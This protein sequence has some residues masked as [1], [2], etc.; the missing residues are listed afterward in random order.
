MKNLSHFE[1]AHQTPTFPALPAGES[2][3][4]IID[5]PLAGRVDLFRRFSGRL[6]STGQYPRNA[7][8]QLEMAAEI[9][10]LSHNQMMGALAARAGGILQ[11]GNKW[12]RQNLL[13]NGGEPHTSS[14][15][16]EPVD[17][18]NKPRNLGSFFRAS[19]PLLDEAL[20]EATENEKPIPS[21][22]R[23]TNDPKIIVYYTDYWHGRLA[24]ARAALERF[25]ATGVGTLGQEEADYISDVT[26]A[27]T[28]LN[29]AQSGIV[30]EESPEV[31]IDLLERVVSGLRRAA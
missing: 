29:Q 2:E 15:N 14:S 11:E 1:E 13:V 27:I 16:N 12:A 17:E 10:E 5:R 20:S 3:Q 23:L 31:D 22:Y 21:G 19:K 26:Q 18:A 8:H 4:P 30:P 7:G 25:R 24:S 28:G 9:S 6:G